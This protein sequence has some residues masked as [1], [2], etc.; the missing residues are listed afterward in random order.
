[1]ATKRNATVTN[2]NGAVPL[3]GKSM[4]LLIVAMGGLLTL[5]GAVVVPIASNEAG[6]QVDD[7]M[8]RHEERPKAHPDAIT[9]EQLRDH[10]RYAQMWLERIE[11][12]LDTI[13][14]DVKALREKR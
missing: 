13:Q 7:A 8:Q 6:K 12:S 4:A 2:K 14:A 1:M 11:K 5:A 10:E 9:A 3:T